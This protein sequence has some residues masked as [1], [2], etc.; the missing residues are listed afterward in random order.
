MAY[1]VKYIFELYGYGYGTYWRVELAKDGY[2][3][4]VVTG[5]EVDATA[6][7]TISLEGMGGGKFFTSQGNVVKGTSATL[8]I[9]IENDTQYEQFLEFAAVE[10]REWKMLIYKG[11]SPEDASLSRELFIQPDVFTHPYQDYPFFIQLTATDEVG[12]LSG[13]PFI[14]GA[15]RYSERKSITWFLFEIMN[16]L[17][18]ERQMRV[19]CE[20]FADGMF[21]INSPLHVATVDPTKYI[22][23]KGR[24]NETVMN[25]HEV[26]N[27]LL[28][29]FGCI[30]FLGVDNKWVI[31]RINDF[32]KDAYTETTYTAWDGLT[33]AT[34]SN[35]IKACNGNTDES[36]INFVN[37]S[38]VKFDWRWNR[39]ILQFYVGDSGN[40]V[41]DGNLAPDAW[42]NDNTLTT[43]TKFVAP[44]SY[45]YG[46]NYERAEIFADAFYMS[47]DPLT[48]SV[49]TTDNYIHSVEGGNPFEDGDRIIF[50]LNDGDTMPS[51]IN[52]NRPYYVVNTDV[53]GAGTFQIAQ[54][55]GGTPQNIN[56]AGSGDFWLGEV[57]TESLD[58]AMQ[59]NEHQDT[60][61]SSGT[62][63]NNNG[64]ISQ[65][66]DV[67]QQS[68]NTWEI[69]FYWKLNASPVVETQTYPG[70][71]YLGI[72]VTTSGGTIYY[73]NKSTDTWGTTPHYNRLE[74]A[75]QRYAWK[76]EEFTSDFPANG[77]FKVEFYQPSAETLNATN[78][79]ISK[80]EGVINIGGE[81][82]VE[83]IE[84]I[85]EVGKEY[86]YDADTVIL[87]SGDAPS[88][89]YQG[90][91]GYN[92]GLAVDWARKGVT[93][94][95]ELLDILL[96]GYMNNYGR[97]TIVINGTLKGNVD[98]EDLIE[99]Y[100]GYERDGEEITPRLMLNG[101]TLDV[102][103][104]TWSGEW[105][106]IN[107]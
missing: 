22:V 26:V 89:I 84:K 21:P 33:T 85:A 77:E 59:L 29:P 53:T 56:S 63:T 87:L 66:V 8:R 46:W 105:I 40:F 13:I 37:P 43:W 97:S 18:V 75:S 74:D 3:G 54:L 36:I 2:V 7:L 101:G 35:H 30:M 100:S 83:F 10:E 11:T 92:G 23:N 96:Q 49:N 99:T 104:G 32:A 31:K 98:V 38:N 62:M 14:N 42:F 107:E 58:Y 61:W 93:E 5:V 64:V 47:G 19:V 72:T 102:E 80:I 44:P 50:K 52:N 91:I 20:V 76:K 70:Y 17:G 86:A 68:G 67:L 24:E 39:C 88:D 25:C 95:K 69:S 79:Q 6:G 4:S 103:D 78:I 51:G 81:T 15:L 71:G 27:D 94:S 48:F 12:R 65:A 60:L 41:F 73:Y 82:E 9:L 55:E 90:H 1:G 106:E 28:K 45:D 16:K 57:G 34:V